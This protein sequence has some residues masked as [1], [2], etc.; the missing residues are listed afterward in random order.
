MHLPA[1]LFHLLS[2]KKAPK[3]QHGEKM[4]NEISE[5]H[6]KVDDRQRKKLQSIH[7]TSK[8]QIYS[9]SLPSGFSQ[10]KAFD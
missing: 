1:P 4:T 5:I 6:Q 3:K 10:Y 8:T 7:T 2:L 9:F